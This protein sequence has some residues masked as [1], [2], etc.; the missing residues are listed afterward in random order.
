M[1]AVKERQQLSDHGLLL[2]RVLRRRTGRFRAQYHSHAA[3]G[4][5]HRNAAQ[6]L[7]RGDVKVSLPGLMLRRNASA[8]GQPVKRGARQLRYPLPLPFSRLD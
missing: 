3:A 5:A 1:G 7:R 4:D 6:Q 8:V 2:P